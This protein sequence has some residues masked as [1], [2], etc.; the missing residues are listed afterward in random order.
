[1]LTHRLIACLDV[2]GGRVVKGTR[3]ESLRDMGDPVELA[4]RYEAEGA[5]EI[6][7]LDIGAGPEERATLLEL[8]ARTAA[9]LFI[10]LTIGGGIRSVEDVRAALRAG[11]D[12]V[13]INSAMVTDPDL[14]SRAA[15][16]FG[17]QCVVASIDARRDGAGW[18]VWT[19]GGRIDTGLDAVAWATECA[20]RGAGEILLTSIDQDGGRDGYD[21]ALTRA[22]TEAVAVPVIAS[23]GAGQASHVAEVLVQTGAAAALVAGILHDGTHTIGD[24]K[25]AMSGAGLRVRP[26]PVA[27]GPSGPAVG[28][29]GELDF[30]KG[31]GLV[32]VVV[33]DARTRAVLMVAHADRAALEQTIASGEMH[34]RSRTRG[35]WHKGATSGNVQRVVELR[36]DCD[37]DSVLALVE[38]AGPACHTG[39]PSCFGD[40]VI[41]DPLDRLAAVIAERST[42]PG[43]QGY[44]RRLLDDRNLRL[45]KIGEEATELVMAL[46]DG[47]QARVAEEAADL[48][49]HQLVALQGMGLSLAA[50][51]AVLAGRLDAESR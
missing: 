35:A 34:F 20:R 29:L 41:T 1:M 21:L 10:P 46:A 49:Y 3:F 13:A 27:A 43:H 8:A 5:D 7:F 47:D 37:R 4:R 44:T 24:L 6:V 36:P 11:A 17:A 39:Q 51:R 42:N 14:V 23:G 15:A 32:T 18:R 16:E 31:N 19:G 22:V 28:W 2:L 48:L 38:P 50:V 9:E 30:A 25:A 33:Q 26:V 45:K 40:P 12:K